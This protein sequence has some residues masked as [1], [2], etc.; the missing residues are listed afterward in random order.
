MGRGRRPDR[1]C[2]L[3]EIRV[4]ERAN[5]DEDQMRPRLRLTEKRRPAR[6]TESPVHLV[7]TVRD[8]SVVARRSGHR[9]SRG[10]KAGVDRSAAGTDILAISAPAYARDNRRL[11]AFPAN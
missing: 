4:V 10:A 7:A 11:R 6:R 9:K 5:P 2:R 1:H 3:S 8:A